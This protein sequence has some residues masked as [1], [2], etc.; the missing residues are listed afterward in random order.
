MY[1]HLFGFCFMLVLFNSDACTMYIPHLSLCIDSHRSWNFC[2]LQEVFVVRF[3]MVYHTVNKLLIQVSYTVN[4][5]LFACEK[6][7]RCAR[8][9]HR[10][11]NQSL[12]Q[13]CNNITGWDKACNWSRKLVIAN[14]FIYST[15]ET[16]SLRIKVGLQYYPHLILVMV[17]VKLFPLAN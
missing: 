10:R 6:C 2:I 1:S 13:G 17:I 15:L 12:P 16:K 7:S 9:P 8:E 11:L 4:Q 5:L 3:V 14:H